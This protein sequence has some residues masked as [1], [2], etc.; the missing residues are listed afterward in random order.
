LQTAD[1]AL[2]A[3]TNLGKRPN[4]QPRLI[5]YYNSPYV[6]QW[7]DLPIHFGDG[8]TKNLDDAVEQFIDANFNMRS[9]KSGFRVETPDLY[10]ITTKAYAY[11][12]KTPVTLKLIVGCEK[13][14]GTELIGSFDL[15]PDQMRSCQMTTYMVPGD[16]ILPSVVDLDYPLASTTRRVRKLRSTKVKV[17]RTNR[18]TSKITC[19]NM[20]AAKHAKFVGWYGRSR[21]W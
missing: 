20:A 12:A 21:A 13:H 3:A 15:S 17:S 6:N 7:F 1:Q 19:R 18:S 10:R 11:Q 16:Y 8:V 5:D 2:D 14:G 9:D 4:Q